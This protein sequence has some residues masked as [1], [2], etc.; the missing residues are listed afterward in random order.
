MTLVQ[1]LCSRYLEKSLQGINSPEDNFGYRLRSMLS[2]TF[3][4][5][6]RYKDLFLLVWF[7]FMY[8]SKTHLKWSILLPKHEIH[9]MSHLSV[10]DI[11]CAIKSCQI[12]IF[13]RQSF[14]W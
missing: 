3:W 10:I 5:I 4:D 1:A 7:Q 13:Q 6:T 11:N 2:L 12:S 9:V 8:L 14:N